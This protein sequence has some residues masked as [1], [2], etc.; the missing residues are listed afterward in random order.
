V[1]LAVVEETTESDATVPLIVWRMHRAAKYLGPA[2]YLPVTLQNYSCA[3]CR[4]HGTSFLPVPCLV[5]RCVCPRMIAPSRP[6]GSA[7]DWKR[8]AAAGTY[9]VR[10]MALA[11]LFSAW[12]LPQVGRADGELVYVTNVGSGTV[13]VIDTT[14]N[15]VTAT[16]TVGDE[17]TGIAV[18]P[19]GSRVYVAN[20]AS[21]T[22]SV[23]DVVNNSVAHLPV[24]YAPSSVVTS[25]DGAFAFVT[26]QNVVRVVD[27]ERGELVR[28]I[29]ITRSPG[30]E[31]LALSPDGSQALVTNSITDAVSIL[32]MTTFE[33]IAVLAAEAAPN[34]IAMDDGRA[35]I[36]N[37]DSDS[38]LIVDILG[39]SV[40]ASIPV[41]ARPVDLAFSPDGSVLYVANNGADSVSVIDGSDQAVV[42]T[43]TVGTAPRSVAFGL[44][45]ALAYV[46]NE[47]SENVSVIDT[48]QRVVAA[49]IVVEGRPYGVAVGQIPPPPPTLTATN[50]LTARRT[51][52]PTATVTETPLPPP[53]TATPTPTRAATRTLTRTRAAEPT[54]TP[55][56]CAPVF[57]PQGPLERVSIRSDG[58]QANGPSS[59]AVTNENGTCI[60]FWS[61]ATNLVP[62]DTNGATDVF[63]RDLVNGVTE[64]VSV[65]SGGKQG[66]GSSQAQGFRPAVDRACTCVAFSSDAT[67][68]VPGDTNGATDIFVR[69]LVNGVTER[70]SVGSGGQEANG[71]SSFPSVSGD[72]RFVAFQSAATNLV[73][74]DTNGASD[75]FVHDRATGETVRVNVT[76]DGT[77]G[78]AM[79]IT[80]SIS[81]DG[82]CV[83]FVSAASTLSEGDT[84]D[85]KDIYVACGGAVICRASVSSDAEEPNDDSSLPSLSE[86]G[87][88]VTF[89]SLA[90]NLIALDL[91][92]HADVFVHDCG[93]AGTTELVSV[94][95]CG[96]Q[97][98]DRSFAPSISGN[99][100]FVAFGSLASNVGQGQSTG[101]HSQIYVRDRQDGY[102]VAISHN[103]AGHPAN[104]SVPDM[105]PSISLDGNSVA[106]ASLASD[107]AVGD[108]NE[109]MDA[110]ITTNSM[111]TPTRT[112]TV[113]RTP[114]PVGCLTN[115]DCP[116]EQVCVDNRCVTPT[117]TPTATRTATTTPTISC[118]V[119]EDCPPGKVCVD[120]DCVWAEPTIPV[121]TPTPTMPVPTPACRTDED[122]REGRMCHAGRCL[123]RIQ[124]GVPMVAEL[125]PGEVAQY[126]F[127]AREGDRVTV[128]AIDLSGRNCDANI[129]LGTQNS[130]YRIE[131]EHLAAGTYV[132]TVSP[133]SCTCESPTGC[134]PSRLSFVLNASLNFHGPPFG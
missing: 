22:L 97:G 53:P 132:M 98:D 24:G 79:S 18:A 120:G 36:A 125:N 56:S 39:E 77:Q 78:D 46:T 20:R 64:R 107:L 19:N 27:T 9:C 99:G 83:A 126:G 13:S 124:C 112:R 15:S 117:P 33:I 34:G 17:P 47:G 49:T 25:P 76:T 62:G 54:S 90:S 87:Q 10:A 38:V 119:D 40:L 50:T 105:P 6:V 68:L 81:A 28:N 1:D 11:L 113:T 82:R 130:R 48:A 110:F 93:L 12:M 80:P 85:K 131:S 72:C 14:A 70:I 35:Y 45:G 109:V 94:F 74:D 84:N 122:C 41:G 8:C 108:T 67:N 16:I 69:D 58:G 96:A 63:V 5:L 101:G 100:R 51:A 118:F 123:P 106:L 31:D 75:I 71:P 3:K 61:N 128:D 121:P 73:P 57:Y 103:L 4:S 129:Q 59:G 7:R 30:V 60:A 2:Q 88:L 102:T 32:D 91:N 89:G 44:D 43:I 127:V 29:F 55:S 86:N 115:S 26:D 65:A 111:P 92:D 21:G 95:E 52:T 114:T 66:N 133:E 37:R 42:A 23:I 134:P 116:S 104:G